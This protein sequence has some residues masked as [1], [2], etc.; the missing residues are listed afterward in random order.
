M[1]PIDR[2]ARTARAGQETAEASAQ[3]IAR[4]LAIMGEA[5]HDRLAACNEELRGG[6]V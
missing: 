3:V 6:G 2:A 1:N 5:V 4:R